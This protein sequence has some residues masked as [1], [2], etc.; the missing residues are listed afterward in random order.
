MSPAAR[1]LHQRLLDE[2]PGSLPV[3]EIADQEALEELIDMHYVECRL[4][5][6]GPTT[7]VCYAILMPAGW[8]N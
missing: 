5:G 6:F 2:Q 3:S 1:T 4:I 7:M 8:R